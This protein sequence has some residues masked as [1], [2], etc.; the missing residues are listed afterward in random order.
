M[1]KFLAYIDAS[2]ERYRYLVSGAAL[3]FASLFVMVRFGSSVPIVFELFSLVSFGACGFSLFCGAFIVGRLHAVK[4]Y[5]LETAAVKASSAVADDRERD[6]LANRV[7]GFGKSKKLVDVIYKHVFGLR[8]CGRP[9]REMT[10][11]DLECELEGCEARLLLGLIAGVL[12]F[13]VY[14]LVYVLVLLFA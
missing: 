2:I 4:V 12:C 3:I 5:V 14:S 9:I 6:P 1:E 7:L 10:M 13:A 8:K 11:F